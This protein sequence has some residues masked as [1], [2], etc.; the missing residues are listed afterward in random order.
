MSEDSIRSAI[1]RPYSGY[2]RSIVKKAA[3]LVQSVSRNHGFADGN[4][5][6]TVLLLR[7]LLDKSGYRLAPVAGE[8][9][10]Y[11]IEEMILGVIAGMSLDDLEAWFAARLAR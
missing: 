11:A 4:K 6:T 10:D 8:D 1:E 9:L 5:R 2:Y 7:L 3:A